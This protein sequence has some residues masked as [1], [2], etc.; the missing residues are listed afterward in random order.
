M[1]NGPPKCTCATQVMQL[2]VGNAPGMALSSSSSYSLLGFALLLKRQDRGAQTRA[3]CHIEGVSLKGGR[4]RKSTHLTS[5]SRPSNTLR[6][7]EIRKSTIQLT[8]KPHTQALTKFRRR[9]AYPAVTG[10]VLKLANL[11]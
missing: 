1:A 4:V 5:P 2:K 7:S 11:K 8:L 6:D 10:L 9:A 3:A